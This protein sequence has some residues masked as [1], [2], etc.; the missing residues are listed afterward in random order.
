MFF[1]YSKNK[2]ENEMTYALQHSFLGWCTE[3]VVLKYK[4]TNGIS[5]ATEHLI[6]QH[7]I[8]FFG[9]GRGRQR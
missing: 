6:T 4:T 8:I 5:L 1:I 7:V 9:G 3:E 2:M